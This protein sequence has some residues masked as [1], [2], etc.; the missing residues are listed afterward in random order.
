MDLER[1]VFYKEGRTGRDIL[2]LLIQWFHDR[3]VSSD[4]AL[5]LLHIE[6]LALGQIHTQYGQDELVC[7]D[8]ESLLRHLNRASNST[9]LA[10]GIE[11][12]LAFL[13][14]NR[15]IYH[16]IEVGRHPMVES[17]V[18]Q[19]K[20]LPLSNTNFAQHFRASRWLSDS[21]GVRHLKQRRLIAL[22][23]A[24][25]VFLAVIGKLD[26]LWTFPFDPV[27]DTLEEMVL[28]LTDEEGPSVDANA[29][30]IEHLRLQ[31]WHYANNRYPLSIFHFHLGLGWGSST[32]S[33]IRL[34]RTGYDNWKHVKEPK[35]WNTQPLEAP[36]SWAELSQ[37]LK[38]DN[39]KGQQPVD[40]LMPWCHG[41]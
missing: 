30:T 24:L 18:E 3:V 17:V 31:Y 33:N 9:M 35:D 25:D 19:I 14:L 13:T 2:S 16:C 28:A 41:L 15:F 4:A 29:D 34:R 12:E 37:K 10:L 39:A 27:L 6:N 38:D 23:K 5:P 21:L 40:N 20:G 1:K 36:I 32:S 11:C 7:Q 8:S 22:Q 26:D